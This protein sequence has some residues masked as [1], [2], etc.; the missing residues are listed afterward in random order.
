MK[1]TLISRRMFIGT[2]LTLCLGAIAYTQIRPSATIF[3]ANEIQVILHASYHLFPDSKVG[4]SARDLQISHY[5]SGVFADK[6]LFKEDKDRFL[7]G[8][9]WLEES[10]YE[11]FNKSFLNL[12][13]NEKENLFQEIST[14]RWGEAFM[15]TCLNYIFEALLSAPVY[16]SNTDAIGWKWLDHS[17]GFPQPK[18][19]EEIS[20]DL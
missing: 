11:V 3:Y 19:K 12:N 14:E 10:S 20:Y 8:G 5:L 6:R 4:P 15:F 16:G 7:K 13:K 18:T 1:D 2:S 17:P 9:Y